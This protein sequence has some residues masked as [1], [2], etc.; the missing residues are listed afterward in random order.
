MP[1]VVIMSSQAQHQI[2][3]EQSC[4][5]GLFTEGREETEEGKKGKGTGGKWGAAGVWL[6]TGSWF[7]VL[8]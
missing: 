5:I 1:V 7:G 6:R 2:K 3:A 4:G 8:H